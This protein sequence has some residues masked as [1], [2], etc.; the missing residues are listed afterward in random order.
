MSPIAKAEWQHLIPHRGAMSLLDTVLAWDDA[1][2]HLSAVSHRD[3]AN[4]LRSDG[5][6]RALHLCEYGAQAMAA[7][8]GLL[9]QREGKVA[10]PG[11]LVSLRAVNLHIERIDDLPGAI[12]VH[13]EKLLDGGASWQYAFRIEHEG[14]LLAEGRAAVMTGATAP[15]NA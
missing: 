3:T 14:R 5:M 10:A 4:P 8:G 2:I 15:L 7:H 6:L 9:A 11:L 12:D 1:T 13:A